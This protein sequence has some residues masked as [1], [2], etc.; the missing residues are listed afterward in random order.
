MVRLV[1]EGSAAAAAG[2]GCFDELLSI[3]GE[4]VTSAVH[5]VEMIRDAP[6]GTLYVRVRACPVRLSRAAATLQRTWA[7]VNRVRHGMVRAR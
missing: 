5:A 3:N 7:R 2:L 4:R 6:I 1:H